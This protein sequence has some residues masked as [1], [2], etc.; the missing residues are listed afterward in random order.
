MSKLLSKITITCIF[1]AGAIAGIYYFTST[2]GNDLAINSNNSAIAQDDPH[3]AT[4]ISVWDR[5]TE[6]DYS[7]TTEMTVYR[8]PTCGCCGVWLEHAQ[9]STVSKSKWFIR[10]RFRS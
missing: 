9:T 5:E 4:L 8:S 7:G 3:Q 2:P 10:S 6:A 1:V